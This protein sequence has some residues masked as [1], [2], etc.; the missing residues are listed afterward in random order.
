MLE[1]KKIKLLWGF[2]IHTDRPILGKIP[3]I[4]NKRREKNVCKQ[5]VIQFDK[6]ENFNKKI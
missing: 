4:K 5:M 3:D 2:T 6:K 1:N